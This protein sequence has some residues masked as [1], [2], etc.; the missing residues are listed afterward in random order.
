HRYLRAVLVGPN[1]ILGVDKFADSAVIIKARLKTRPI[2]QW[3]VGREFNRRMKIRFDEYNI[4]IP[5]P[6][7][8]IYFGVDKDGKAPAAPLKLENAEDILLGKSQN[9]E[10]TK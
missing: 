7:Q 6:H 10:N 2:K 8:T 9:S 3:E 5:F 4:E 1:L